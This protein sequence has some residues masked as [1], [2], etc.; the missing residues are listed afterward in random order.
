VRGTPQLS[1]SRAQATV[2]LLAALRDPVIT[3]GV[4]DHHDVVAALLAFGALEH[5]MAAPWLVV[6]LMAM[7]GA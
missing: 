1:P 6:A 2:L 4:R 3:E 7:L 5:R